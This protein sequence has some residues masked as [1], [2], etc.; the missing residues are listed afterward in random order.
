MG[1][2]PPRC[3]EELQEQAQTQ[4]RRPARSPL[5]NHKARALDR[6]PVSARCRFRVVIL[7]LSDL[8]LQAR[9]LQDDQDDPAEPGQEVPQSPPGSELEG[10]GLKDEL[11]EYSVSGIR[12]VGRGA[13]A[14]PRPNRGFKH[15]LLPLF[16]AGPPAIT[17]APAVVPL[18]LAPTEVV[19]DAEVIDLVDEEGEVNSGLAPTQEVVEQDVE[20]IDLVDEE[21]EASGSAARATAAGAPGVA[22]AR[23]GLAAPLPLLLQQAT[24]EEAPVP[25]PTEVVEEEA[26]VMG[27]V[28]EEGVVS[29]PAQEAGAPGVQPDGAVRLGV[30]PVDQ[31]MHQQVGGPH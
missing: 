8:C 31:Q 24:G 17:A 10:A 16:P 15:K 23:H 6:V 28:D 13:L 21:G 29:G 3:R 26:E 25:A 30:L 4:H 1:G 18:Q 27:Q 20:V 19:E 7:P 12:A 22:A 11:N 2:L 5:L 9:A 14:K